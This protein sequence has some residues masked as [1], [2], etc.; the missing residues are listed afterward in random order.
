MMEGQPMIHAHVYLTTKFP[1]LLWIGILDPTAGGCFFGPFVMEG[2]IQTGTLELRCRRPGGLGLEARGTGGH[3]G[4]LKAG[5]HAVLS[6]HFVQHGIHSGAVVGLDFGLPLIRSDEIRLVR[7]QLIQERVGQQQVVMIAVFPFCTVAY[8]APL[9]IWGS[10]IHQEG[11]GNN[12]AG[13]TN[14]IHDH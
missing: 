5:G 13:G 10:H 3:Q 9:L 4:H 1:L 2:E 12:D 8:I 14:F 6:A 7:H 11:S